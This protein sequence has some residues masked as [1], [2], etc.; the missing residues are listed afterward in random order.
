MLLQLCLRGEWL[1]LEQSI[2][3]QDRGDPELST[4]DEESGL[5]VLMV[6]VR[7]NRLAVVERLLELGVN[8]A[9]R[10]KDGRT[11]L[12]VAAAHAK[13][14][15]IKLLVRKSDP[16]TPG[17]PGHQLPLHYAASRCPPSLPPLQTLLRASNRDARLTPD[18]DGSIAL[19][20]AVEAGNVGGVKELLG[21]LPEAQLGSQTRVSGD[22]AL[23]VCIRRKDLEMAKVLLDHGAPV[24]TQNGEGQTPLHIAA[25][26]GDEILLKLLYQNKANPNITDQMERSPLHIAVERGHAHVVE[27]LTEKF[28]SNVL[29]RTKDGST[30]LHIASQW[31]HP[32]TALALLRKGV[33]LHMPNKLGEVCLHAASRRGHAAVV[34]ALLQKGAMLDSRTRQGLSALH[35][36]VQSCRPQVVQVLLGYGACVQLHGGQSGESPLHMAARVREGEKVAEMLLK[37][38]AEVNAEQQDGETAVHAAARHGSVKMLRALLEEGGDPTWRSKAGESPLHVAVRHRHAHVV[39]ELLLHLTNQ[40]S[41]EE[42]CR[43]VRQENTRGEACLHLAVASGV[44]GQ[45]GEEGEEEGQDVRIIRTLMEYEADI[46]A[47]TTETEETPLH[48]CA[49]EGDTATLLVMLS[50]V[51]PSLQQGAVNKHYKKGWSPLLLA[52]EQ[53]HL[54]VV[55][56]L[57]QHQ[58]RVDVFDQEGRSAL[59]LASQR[60]HV[61]IVDVLL[62]HNAFVNAKTKLGLTPL[63]LGAQSGSAHLVSLLVTKHQASI[64][65]LSLSKQTPLHLA[66]VC[67]HLEVCSRLL[68]L[69]ADITA[70]DIRGQTPLHLAAESDHSEVVQLFLRQRPELATLANM[71]GATC[72]HIAAAKGSLAVTRELLS[73]SLGGAGALD[74]KAHGSGPL[75]LA[76]SGGHAEVVKVLLEAGAPPLLEDAEGM[77][78]VHLA[79]RRGHTHLLEVLKHSLSL[80]ISSTK[81]GLSALHVAACHGQV[82]VVRELL[83]QVPATMRSD[84][85]GAGP[86]G[87]T[88][89]ESGYTPLHLA[90][91]SGHEGVVRLLLNSPGVQADAQTD[92]QGSS[93][94]HLAAQRGHVTVVGLLLSRSAPLLHLRDEA[95][96]TCLHLAAASGHVAMVRQL[97]GQGADINITDQA[98]WTALHCAAQAGCLDVVRHLVESGGNTG[99]ECQEGRTPLQYA[100]ME[101][102]LHTLSFLLRRADNN[103]LR[104]LED[105]KFVFDLM[106]CGRLNSDLSLDEFILSS[107]APLDTAVRLSRALGLAALREKERS[108]DLSAA[109]GHCEGVASDLLS[110]ASMGVAGPGPGS[111]PGSGSGLGTGAVLCSVDHRGLSQLDLLLEAGLQGV[112]AQPAVQAYLSELWLGCLAHWDPWRLLLLFMAMLLCPPLWVALSLPLTHRYNTVPI[113]KFMSHLVSHLFLLLLLILTTV[114]PPLSPPHLGRLTPS[115]TDWLLLSW[116]A[117]MLVSELS[118]PGERAGLAWVRV[119]VLLFAGSALLCHFLAVVLQGF[120][121]AHLHCLFARN[122]LLAVAMALGF[123]QLLDF[124]SFHHLFGPWAVI[125]RDLL[126]DLGRFAVILALFHTAF[127][128]SLTALCQP[129]Y[130]YRHPDPAEEEP[131]HTPLELSVLLF[132]ALFGLTDPEALPPLRQSPPTAALLAR[133]AFGSYLVVTVIVLINLLIA[134]M[135][136][137]YQR[138]QARSDAEWKFGRAVLI[139][140]MSR[141]SGTPSP[142]NLVTHLYHYAKVLCKHAGK[143]CPGEGG[144]LKS[145]EED[146]EGGGGR[147]ARGSLDLLT[148]NRTKK[149]TQIQPEGGVPGCW[150]QAGQV[151]VEQ[152]SD[153]SLV[154]QRY[155]ALRGQSPGVG[156]LG[157]T[158]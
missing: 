74:Y 157:V 103:T 96:R 22:A 40:R 11:A 158:P 68:Q 17:G 59:H 66:A 18:K 114:Y 33:P 141:K 91:Q 54:T 149:R 101:T 124:L 140:D 12:H 132:F 4:V 120:S 79:A 21:T 47:V 35:L 88:L 69:G 127:T 37:S 10:S 41:R 20:L 52:A 115:W 86:R 133:L 7:E 112:V 28:K 9:D 2:K 53:G 16:N 50:L 128:L 81:T 45:A 156:H 82:E 105:R 143:V 32:D 73:F 118:Q 142:L 48:Y 94:L 42:A 34:R 99:V 107:P 67:G 145:E 49:R 58:A 83:T 138:I 30:L 80:S 19:L 43:C 36:A 123:V 97:L 106:V 72:T 57:L 44:R 102:H 84:A 6:A 148:R 5:T 154:V 29:A 70:S 137:T 98:G 117:G 39:E 62:S 63:H 119:L 113:V 152:V 51:P 126:R 95:G 14:D 129:V 38:G 150:R 151:R 93:P 125:I 131:S 13:D 104:L 78:A 110:M 108:A 61:D 60:G 27:I 111:V 8:P 134:M 85:P 136:N 144:E 109:A 71:E 24:N 64:D 56:T 153:W 147:G 155:Q 25:F 3:G 146:P 77:T 100:A 90:A 31:G 92:V 75:H 116:M 87:G 122:A 121:P 65:A 89:A 139:R 76:S 46:T 135:S 26:E 130:P 23:H 15:I 55:R 1:A